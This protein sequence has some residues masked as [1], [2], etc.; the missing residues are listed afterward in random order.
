MN[1]MRSLDRLFD[2]VGKTFSIRTAEAIAILRAD[3]ELQAKMEE[4]ARQ[5][6]E[7]E[8]SADDRAE[9]SALVSANNVI[10]ILQAKARNI[11]AS[12]RKKS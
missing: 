2:P 1:S 11:L 5:S 10:A 9:Y 7:G 12:R 3:P 8:L 6:T 4:F